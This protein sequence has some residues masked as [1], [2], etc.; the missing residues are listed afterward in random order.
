MARSSLPRH[1]GKQRETRAPGSCRRPAHGPVPQAAIIRAIKHIQYH[2][3]DAQSAAINNARR[4]V[5]AVRDLPVG[6]VIS[7][8]DLI[9]LRSNIGI[10]IAS[11]DEVVGRTVVEAIG[12]DLPLQW[13]QLG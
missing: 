13:N 9:A 4:R 11:W 1:N 10:E 3:L 12:A 5:I 8:E 2:T 7:G 6:H